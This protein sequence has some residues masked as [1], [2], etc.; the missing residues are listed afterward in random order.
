MRQQKRSDYEKVQNTEDG[1]LLPE[2][3]YGR[4]E[5]RFVGAHRWSSP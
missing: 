2:R 4:F 5:S 1:G 3:G